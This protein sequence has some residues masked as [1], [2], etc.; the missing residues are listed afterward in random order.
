MDGD[1]AITSLHTPALK[2]SKRNKDDEWETINAPEMLCSFEFVKRIVRKIPT[3]LLVNENFWRK[4][5]RK[6]HQNSVHNH[7]RNL[8]K[9]K[10][11]LTVAVPCFH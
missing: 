2:K 8:T 4:K 10:V 1:Y 11:S 7:C 5:S 3:L 6:Q 9:L